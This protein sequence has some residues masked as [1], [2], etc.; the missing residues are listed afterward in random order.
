MAPTEVDQFPFERMFDLQTIP[1]CPDSGD[2]DAADD[3][4]AAASDD[5]TCKPGGKSGEK[6]GEANAARKLLLA[7]LM[8]ALADSAA[9]DTATA[10][11]DEPPSS[12][13]SLDDKEFLSS[14]ALAA[15]SRK[16]KATEIGEVPSADAPVVGGS[17]EE[18]EVTRQLRRAIAAVILRGSGA[19]GPCPA[20]ASPDAPSPPAAASLPMVTTHAPNPVG[21]S[22]AHG[23]LP[24]P[25]RLPIA[26]G[27][28]PAAPS[29]APA[30]LAAMAAPEALACMN[31][32]DNS[33]DD[34]MAGY[35]GIPGCGRGTNGA[36]DHDADDWLPRNRGHKDRQMEGGR[37]KA[38]SMAERQRWERISEGLQKL[39]LVVRGHGDTASMLDKAVAYVDALQRRVTAL[40]TALLLHQPSCK[41][42]ERVISPSLLAETVRSMEFV[43]PEQLRLDGRRPKE[44]RQLKCELGVLRS[45]DGW[46]TCCSLR[47]FPPLAA[48][49]AACVLVYPPHACLP[50]PCISARPM[51]LRPPHASPPAPCISARPMHL[52]PPH[53]SPPA[54]CLLHSLFRFLLTF[55]T[56]NIPSTPSLLPQ[57]FLSI[58]SPHAPAPVFLPPPPPRS[59]LPPFPPPRRGP[60]HPS[61]SPPSSLSSHVTNRADAL[62]DRA[63]VRCEYG[64]AS[65]STGERR[66]RGKMDRCVWGV[67]WGV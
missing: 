53:A 29:D 17:E 50:A 3:I 35:S 40:E 12:P 61:T 58:S 24:M 43:S 59:P 38:R 15:G 10:A 56:C 55:A 44:L 52:R 4:N 51:H 22:I 11:A 62:P 30:L 48:P 41:R 7:A 32:Y 23:P 20:P 28:A 19:G 1:V 37:I 9:D 47:A 39:R 65:F 13:E 33:D 2:I 31:Y 18:L 54:P 67:A 21:R 26:N 5:Y 34:M 42:P 66:R 64:M 36:A 63:V 45:A 27:A 25:F 8:Q 14:V 57:L 60:S 16:R 46:V 49:A 6:R